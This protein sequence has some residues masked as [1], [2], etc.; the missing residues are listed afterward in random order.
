MIVL[1]LGLITRETWQKS[2]GVSLAQY[3]LCQQRPAFLITSGNT[4]DFWLDMSNNTNH[5]FQNSRFIHPCQNT[6]W[7]VLWTGNQD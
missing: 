7:C 1:L 2:G 6:H 4:W 5:P 3:S